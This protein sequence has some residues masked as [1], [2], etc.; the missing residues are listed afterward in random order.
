MRDIWEH[1]SLVEKTA[2]RVGVDASL[3]ADLGFEVLQECSKNH[4]ESKGSFRR[5]ASVALKNAF[6]RYKRS[7]KEVPLFEGEEFR[8]P[9]VEPLN[10]A[11]GRSL[12]DL[13]SQVTE[14][15]YELLRDWYVSGY[16]REELM[17][18]YGRS[19]QYL[20]QWLQRILKKIVTWICHF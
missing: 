2:K 15:E 17:R 20:W 6:V 19:R 18:K 4:T 3:V 5:Y 7:R 8:Q 16:S 9:V 12:E 14:A 11:G 13:R 10:I 1:L